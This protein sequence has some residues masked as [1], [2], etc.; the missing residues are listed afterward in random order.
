MPR[1]AGLPG[2]GRLLGL[3]GETSKAG[4]GGQTEFGLSGLQDRG[5]QHIQL[6]VLARA[7]QHALP[8]G[9][10]TAGYRGVA[11]FIILYQQLEMFRIAVQPRGRNSDRRCQRFDHGRGRVLFA[12]LDGLQRVGWDAGFCGDN[13][14]RLLA[15]QT[16]ATD[17]VRERH[18]PMIPNTCGKEQRGLRRP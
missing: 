5:Q 6:D 16:P 12:G 9:I 1:G 18:R 2:D 4:L 17:I 7:Q 13:G 8:H 14:H 11:V 10:E 3:L 15:G